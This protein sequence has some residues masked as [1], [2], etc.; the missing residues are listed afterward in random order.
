VHASGSD[1]H[2]LYLDT[3][4]SLKQTDGTLQLDHTFAYEVGGTLTLGGGGNISWSPPDVGPFTQP[5]ASGGTS[6]LSLWSDGV[7]SGLIGAGATQVQSLSG[8]GTI[9]MAGVFFTPGQCWQLAG[10]NDVGTT[11]TLD[12][13]FIAYCME[14]D[15]SSHFQLTPAINLIPVVLATGPVLIR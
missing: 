10:N 8:G 11:G 5:N 3:G 15:G 13:Q 9:S 4:F 12:S 1:F 14:Q 2:T 6:K 7:G